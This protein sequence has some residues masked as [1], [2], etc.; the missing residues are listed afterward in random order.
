MKELFLIINPTAA[1]GRV[2]KI[3]TDE[4]RPLLDEHKVD[5]DFEMTTHSQHAIDIA[6][7]RVNEGYKIIC[8][9]GGDGTA[10]EVINGILKAEKQAVFGAFTIGTGNDVATA[11]GIPEG[12][13]DAVVDTIINGK[14]KKFDVGYCEKAD[15]YFGGVTSMG[16]D[17]EVAD[18][19][20][21][22]KKS[23]IG[24]G[25][26]QRALF[27]TL[28]KFKPYE[29][30][31]KPDEGS[32]ITGPRMLVSVGNGKRYGA[33]MHICPGAK[34]NDG[35]FHGISL[36]KIRR[37]TLVRLFPK[38]YDGSHITNKA[39]EAFTGEK[40]TIE[41][42]KKPCLYQADGEVL[43]YLPETFITKSNFL[44]VRVPDP[45][46]SYSEIWEKVLNEKKK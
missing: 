46:V 19:S 35:K 25:N 34:P 6:R 5:Y 27:A 26:Y 32:A 31:I 22:V 16:F 15:R 8:S 1:G 20:N 39:V 24:T 40:I 14:D 23:R 12:D 45:W 11:F 21:K 33:G 38:T 3:W 30:I 17:A 18:R 43:G 37:L 4:V 29:I 7:T 28:L 44:T 13:I 10:N 41:S 42:P 2:S 36:K 9:V